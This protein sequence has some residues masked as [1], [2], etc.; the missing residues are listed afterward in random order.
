MGPNQVMG[1]GLGLCLPQRRPV[2]NVRI[3]T[4]YIGVNR[5]WTHCHVRGPRHLQGLLG[6]GLQG[7]CLLGLCLLGLGLLGPSRN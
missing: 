6:L 4:I 3:L 1:L 5:G 2:Q 7:L